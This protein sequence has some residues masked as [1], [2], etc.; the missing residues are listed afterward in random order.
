MAFKAESDDI[1]SSLSLQAEAAS[2]GSRRDAVLCT[3]PYVTVDPDL[4]PLERGARRS[5]TSSSSARRTRRTATLEPRQAGRRHLE[6]ARAGR[7]GLTPR[8]SRSSSRPTTRVT[9][10]SPFLDRILEAIT[11]PCEVLVVVDDAP[12]TRPCRPSRSTPT[13]AAA[14]ADAGQHLRPGSGATRSATAS[15]TPP[16]PVVVVTM[17]DGCDD[18]FQIDEL[19]R[20]VE[21]GVVV[22]AASRYARTGQQVGGPWLKA[23]DVAPRRPEPALPRPGRHQGRDELVQGL[24]DRRSCAT[25]GIE[26]D[27]GFEIG[28]ELVAKARRAPP[29]GRRDPDDLARPRVRRRRTSSSGRGCPATCAGTCYAFGPKDRAGLD[30]ADGSY[31]RHHEERLT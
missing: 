29:A 26:S 21:R 11:L 7:A 9:R 5:P 8:V 6:P 28:I 17:A 2:C 3:D 4:A 30:D 16:P 1:R 22:A 15:T 13:R 31:E 20:L 27:A 24:L 18:P 10:S 19:T 25:V 14:R 12:T 23:H